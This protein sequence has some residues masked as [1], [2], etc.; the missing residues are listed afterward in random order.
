MI[1][2]QNRPSEWTGGRSPRAGGSISAAAG[3]VQRLASPARLHKLFAPR[4]IAL[5]GASDTSGWARNIHDSLRAA[6]FQGELI[7]VHPRHPSAFG[8]PARKSLR[9]L[10][11]PVDLAFALVPTEAVEQ[12]VEDA[13][14]AGI[15]SM[16]VLAAGYGERGEEGRER[17]RRLVELAGRHGIT[18]LGPNGLGY[19]NAAARVAPYG[20]VIAPPLVTGRVGVVLQSGALASAVQGFARD[21]AIGL[22]LLV[23]MGNEAMVRTADVIEY[24]IE[25]DATG[26]IA[27]FLEGIRE[28]GRFAA[29]ARR[30]LAA[31]KPIVALKVGRSP[32]GQQAALAHTGA[33]AG[34]D[35]VV[36]AALRQLGVI[37]VRSLEE[38]LATAGLL[39][40]GPPPPGR[41]MGVITASGGACDII[42]DRAH[43]EGIEIP[44][45][46]PETVAALSEVLPSFVDAQNPVDVTGIGLAHQP[47]ATPPA[48]YALEA[49]TRDPNVDFVLNVAMYVPN[50]RPPDPAA[51]EERLDRLVAIMRASSVPVVPATTTC[52]GLGDYARGLLLARGLYE[53]PGLELG[54]AAIG[55][56]VRWREWQERSTGADGPR[57]PAPAWRGGAGSG[58]WAETEGRELLA[59]AGVPMVPAELAH[60]AAAAVDAAA[61][62]GYPVALKACAPGL[63]HKSDIGG[64]ALNLQSPEG[65]R[66][67]F[68]R[69]VA[70]AGEGV[71]GVLVSPMR[72][73][74]QELL[75]GVTVDA[76]FGPVLAVGLGGVWAEA[77]HDV[78]LRVLP[79]DAAEARSMLDELRGAAMLR[80]ARGAEPVDLDRV[81]D[82]LVRLGRAAEMVGPSLRALEVN[83]LRCRGAEVEGLDVLVVTESTQSEVA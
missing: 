66:D 73:G 69:V 51:A 64:V 24:L 54:M 76:T 9:D 43:E 19:I 46:G 32:G 65:V 2:G 80:G 17:E 42:A 23:S 3:G 12:V 30:A 52:T 28:P 38:L 83:P 6:G 45:F 34:D 20:L 41:R 50:A 10:E 53:L 21:R 15:E 71:L 25:D 60:D 5:V 75:A 81:A 29:L 68:A 4:H 62:V 57:A 39:A 67:A 44:A 56:A 1:H 31:R 78:A 79:V 70:G 14:A 49:V 16:V 55:N 18:L 27:L 77:L 13:G 35:A 61:R 63:A 59:A 33:V 48:A 8:I 22:S 36:D 40:A 72:D 7:P 82:V 58:P 74:G 37:R 26:V 11:R 47:R